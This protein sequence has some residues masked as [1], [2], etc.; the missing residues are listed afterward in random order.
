MSSTPDPSRVSWRAVAEALAARLEPHA[1][2]AGSRSTDF[3][4]TLGDYGC[5][6]RATEAQPG[7]C[8]FCGDREAMLLFEA[9]KQ[10]SQSRGEPTA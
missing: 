5:T 8:P 6:H 2:A 7:T 1:E 10:A 4:L 9:K 3:P